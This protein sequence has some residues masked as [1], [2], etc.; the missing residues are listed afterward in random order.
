MKYLHRTHLPPAEALAEAARWFGARL[1]PAAEAPHQRRFSG[2]LGTVTVDVRAE[3]GHFTQV[4]LA[5][6]QVAESELDKFAK[7]FLAVLHARE[8]PGYE[9]RGAY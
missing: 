5:T 2:S 4:T 8:A 6:D 7:R 9:V 3:G 1:A